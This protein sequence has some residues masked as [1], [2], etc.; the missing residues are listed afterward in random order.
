MRAH[1]LL[2]LTLLS[3]CYNP[4]IAPGAQR[5]AGDGGACASGLSCF[6]DGRCYPS[7]SKPNCSPACSGALPVCDK[8]RLVCVACLADSDCPQGSICLTQQ[9]NICKPGCSAAHP[10]CLPDAGTCDVQLGACHGC[11]KDADCTDPQN[12]RCQVDSGRCQPCLPTNDNCSRGTY[13]APL[14]AGGF[15][16]VAGCKNGVN[17]DCGGG[18]DGGVPDGGAAG[19]ACCA[20]QCIDTRS[21]AMNCGG[22]GLACPANAST[23]CASSCTDP[24]FDARNCGACGMVC[25]PANVSAPA[26]ISGKCGYVACLANF[27]DCDMDPANGCERPTGADVMNCGGCNKVCGV[28]ANGKAGCSGGICVP[29]CNADYGDCDGVYANGCESPLKLD[30]KN[31]GKCGGACAN[32]Q[33]CLNGSC[34]NIAFPCGLPLVDCNLLPADGCEGNT[35]YDARNCGKCGAACAAGLSCIAGVC[36]AATPAHAPGVFGPQHSFVMLTT[37]HYITQ[38]G[39]S[40]G[41][42]FPNFSDAFYFC[43]HFYGPNCLPQ[44]FLVAQMTPRLD[45][46][47]MHK[48]GGCTGLGSDIPGTTCQGGPCKI[49][50]WM[51]TTSGIANVVCVCR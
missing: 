40:V 23:C 27:S 44:P 19:G 42:A 17:A 45:Y 9:G 25:N 34:Q 50:N 18:G 6:P 15:S 14:P 37:D 3:G 41:G 24:M 12:P 5:C 29:T 48:N 49:G 10:T 11:L 51:E 39:C 33:T 47:K 4:S 28:V 21:S 16:C 13:C 2:A 36:A 22:C 7:G 43:A 46:P 31:C 8:A 20:H 30:P 1:I 26:C 35:Q 38:G 32:G